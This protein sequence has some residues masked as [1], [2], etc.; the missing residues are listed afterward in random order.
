MAE[1]RVSGRC[2][3]GA[4]SF[5][6]TLKD[7]SMHV[8][9]CAMCRRWTGGV[10]MYLSV[11]PD[12]FSVTKGEA[13]LSVYRSSEAAERGFCKACGSS[14]FWRLH[15]GSQI[16]VSAQSVDDSSRFPFE[17]EIFIDDKPSNYAF[18]NPTRK[19]TSAESAAL[20]AA[21]GGANG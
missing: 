16:D 19:L 20:N 18:A 7:G 2:L 12:S 21:G 5:A 14:L 13:E 1:E 15:D 11:A 9:H 6:A 3:C 8:C 4:V 10:L 17:S